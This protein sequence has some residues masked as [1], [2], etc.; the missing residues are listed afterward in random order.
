MQGSAIYQ[1]INRLNGKR[2]IGSAVNLRSRWGYHRSGLRRN[3]HPN[4]HL[5]AAW[6]LYGGKTFVFT[7]LEYVVDVGLLLEREQYY[8]DLLQPEYNIAPRAGS[9][10][11]IRLTEE[12]KAKMRESHTGKVLPEEHRRKISEGRRRTASYTAKL[13]E[14]DVLEIKTLLQESVLFQREIAARYG[15]VR[16]T[17]RDINTGRTW[18]HVG[19]DGEV[20]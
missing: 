11:G 4:R 16:G 19:A 17:I 3:N 9:N 1:I 14:Q 10:L 13:S 6:N 2:Y 5:Q 8:M 15:V 20:S 18:R 12:T 7:V